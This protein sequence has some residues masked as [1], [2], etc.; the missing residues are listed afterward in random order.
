[1]SLIPAARG[2]GR[3]VLTE[4]LISSFT[5]T[6]LPPCPQSVDAPAPDAPATHAYPSSSKKRHNWDEIVKASAA[7]DEA[8]SKDRSKDPNAGGDQALN[9]MF[10][11]LY[12]DATDDQ[13]KAMIKSY[14]ES[15]GTALSTDWNDVSKVSDH[16][17]SFACFNAGADRGHILAITETSPYSTT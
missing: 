3:S 16:S 9:E 5:F 1:V 7:E 14:Q 10:Q 13:R 2:E 6:N 4:F 12:A 11:K 17:L 8:L 15:N